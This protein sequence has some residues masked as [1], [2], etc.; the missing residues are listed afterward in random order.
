MS[1]RSQSGAVK[2][3]RMVSYAPPIRKRPTFMKRTF[4]KGSLSAQIKAAVAK[5]AEKKRIIG[6]GENVGLDCVTGTT[7]VSLA[8]APVITQGTSH[9]TRVGNSIRVIKATVRGHIN[10]MPYDATNNPTGPPAYVKMWLVRW[11]VGQTASFANTDVDAKFFDTGAGVAGFQGH[12]FDMDAFV[13]D[14]SWELFAEKV[15]KIGAS[16]PTAGTTA[17]NSQVFDGVSPSGVPF[18]FEYGSKLGTCEYN[19][20]TSTC[21]NKNLWLVF[22]PVYANGIISTGKVPVEVNYCSCVDFIDI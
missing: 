13:N 15:V 17:A 21:T 11:K 4:K 18:Y 1:K 16:A 2:M 14:D 8:L 3:T 7:P 5:L 22:Q 9:N 12:M 6:H 19:D 10:I 20:S